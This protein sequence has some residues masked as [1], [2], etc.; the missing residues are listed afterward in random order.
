VA[1]GKKVMAPLRYLISELNFLKLSLLAKTLIVFSPISIPLGS[2]ELFCHYP[3]EHLV[4][5]SFWAKRHMK[6]DSLKCRRLGGDKI[7][8][9]FKGN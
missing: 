7:F 2:L 3:S 4:S 5:Q 1:I 8:S 9:W 6:K